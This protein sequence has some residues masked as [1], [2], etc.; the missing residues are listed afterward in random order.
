MAH[1]VVVEEFEGP[2]GLL[3]ELVERGQLEVTAIAVAEVTSQYLERTSQMSHLTPDELGE[4]LQLGSRLVYIKSLALLPRSDGPEQLEELQQ[5]NLE[6][7]EY[8]RYQRAAR[9]LAKRSGQ[10]TWHRPAISKLSLAE[11]PLPELDIASLAQ[12]FAEAL[13]R[14]QPARPTATL[15]R[16]LSQAEVVARLT[17]L[18][19]RGSVLLEEA[20]SE[21]TDR[22]EIIVLFTAVLELI[23]TGVIRVVQPA[24]FEP[25]RMELAA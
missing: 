1:K 4:F 12:V 24:Q 23:R 16:H 3:L 13:R 14:A 19:G 21:A 17:S 25:I 5:L 8:R 11:L 20:L 22:L 2:L 10:R 9:E 7:A 6:L 15:K 18:L